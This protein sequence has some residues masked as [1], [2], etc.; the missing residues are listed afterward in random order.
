MGQVGFGRIDI[1]YGLHMGE[2]THTHTHTINLQYVKTAKN[3]GWLYVDI[4]KKSEI[5]NKMITNL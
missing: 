1:G 4:T 2:I 3:E 5:S